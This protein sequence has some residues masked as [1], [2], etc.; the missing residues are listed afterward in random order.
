MNEHL[1]ATQMRKIW[2][3]EKRPD[4]TLVITSYKGEE[5]QLHIPAKIGKYPV[6]A[7]GAS[8]FSLHRS[9]RRWPQYAALYG[10]RSV[11]IPEGVTAIE[12]G[13][14]CGCENMAQIKLPDSLTQIGERAFAFCKSLVEIAVPE[15]VVSV[16]REAFCGC[17]ELRRVT[18]PEHMESPVVDVC[19]LGSTPK[20]YE[21]FARCN[22]LEV[23]QAPGIW[24]EKV[25]NPVVRNALLMG[26]LAEKE[27]YKD[28][29]KVRMYADQINGKRASKLLRTVFSMDAAQCI[30]TYGALGK[31]TPE[32][33]EKEFLQPALEVN[34]T[35]CIAFLLDWKDRHLPTKADT[36]QI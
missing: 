3:Y 35:Q 1:N 27:K 18:L 8:A 5:T 10:I 21:I 24:P 33:F 6:T 2:G 23:L 7:I 34:A 14:F 26:F 28:P 25:K 4:G 9:G 29:V 36:Y 19:F 11:I 22:K 13:A 31:I 17:D 16:G 12:D 20:T 30:A 32:N 15:N